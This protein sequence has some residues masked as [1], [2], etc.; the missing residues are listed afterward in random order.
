MARTYKNKV[1]ETI[2][3]GIVIET[4]QIKNQYENSFGMTGHLEIKKLGHLKS[5]IDIR[6]F[7]ELIGRAEYNTNI[8]HLSAQDN[9]DIM[10]DLSISKTQLSTSKCNL[11]RIGAITKCRGNITIN[12]EMHFFGEKNVRNAM[13][14]KK[15]MSKSLENS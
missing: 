7:L 3:N 9:S 1:L 14:K 4:K 11:E 8:V 10:E 2:V 15:N 6:L 13:I 5:M 12:P